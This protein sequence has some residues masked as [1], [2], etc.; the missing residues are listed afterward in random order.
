MLNTGDCHGQPL[1]EEQ[2]RGHRGRHATSPEPV[3]D[4][5]QHSCHSAPQFIQ[6]ARGGPAV[7]LSPSD[8]PRHQFI[9]MGD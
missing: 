8:K 6:T 9:K 4:S 2:P 3:A 5:S 7:S 1:S